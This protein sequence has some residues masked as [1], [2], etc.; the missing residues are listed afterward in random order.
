MARPRV[1]AGAL[2]SDSGGRVLLVKPSYKAGWDIPG[3]YVEPGETPRQACARELAEEL[4]VAIAIGP[5]LVVDWAPHPDE[6]DKV[7]FVFAAGPVGSDF[8]ASLRLQ[9]DELSDA[10]FFPVDRFEYQLPERL[11]RRLTEAVHARDEAAVRYLEHGQR[12]ERA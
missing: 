9:V 12:S 8:A 7:L 11:T 3:G 1:A 4:G 10:D 6:G 5:L 2:I